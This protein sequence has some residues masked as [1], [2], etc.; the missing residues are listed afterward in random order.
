MWTSVP[1]CIHK[2]CVSLLPELGDLP[3]AACILTPV[4]RLTSPTCKQEPVS[5]AKEEDPEADF[6]RLMSEVHG[7]AVKLEV[8]MRVLGLQN[9]QDTMVSLGVAVYPGLRI[10]GRPRHAL[11]AV[12]S[13]LG[14]RTSAAECWL[15]VHTANR[16]RNS[17]QSHLPCRWA[18][19]M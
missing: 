2:L 6:E 13:Q 16:V 8:L 14:V 12:A 4:L 11:H 19:P 5:G 3:A 10:H 1:G 7:T 15:Q 9:C 17:A 18:M